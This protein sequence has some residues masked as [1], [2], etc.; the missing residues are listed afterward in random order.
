[1]TYKLLPIYKSPPVVVIPPL[2][3]NFTIP[4]TF[5]FFSIPTPPLVTIEPVSLSVD[6][7]VLFTKRS[8]FI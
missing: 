7:V 6:S 4:P 5:K 8:S 1:M 3:A 2:V